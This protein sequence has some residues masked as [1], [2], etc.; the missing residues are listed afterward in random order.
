MIGPLVT[1]A[2]HDDLTTADLVGRFL[3]HGGDTEWV[4]ELIPAG[5]GADLFICEA[6][7]FDKVMK[8]HIDYTTLARHLAEIAPKKLVLTHMSDDMLGRLDRLPYTATDDGL[9]IEF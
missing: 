8:Y 5:R 7:F 6:Y 9:V 3:L 1:V 4:D 2:C